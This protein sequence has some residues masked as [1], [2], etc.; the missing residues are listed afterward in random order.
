MFKEVSLDIIFNVLK[1][2]M[3]STS[4]SFLIRNTKF[5]LFLIL[6]CLIV[7]MNEGVLIWLLGSDVVPMVTCFILFMLLITLESP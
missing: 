6:K 1:E 4:C 2:I 3:F 7:L 5:T